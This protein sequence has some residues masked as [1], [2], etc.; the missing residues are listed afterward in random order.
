[1]ILKIEKD[2]EKLAERE[3]KIIHTDGK[4]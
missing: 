2:K 4:T 3:K 1:M